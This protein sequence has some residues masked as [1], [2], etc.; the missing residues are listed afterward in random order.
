MRCTASALRPK[1]K[2]L[3]A[4]CRFFST[5]KA[6]NAFGKQNNW[7]GRRPLPTYVFGF[8]REKNETSKYKKKNWKRMHYMLIAR[9]ER[10]RHEY[11]SSGHCR[12]FSIPLA[13]FTS[14]TPRRSRWF[15]Q[16]ANQFDEITSTIQQ[17]NLA[18]FTERCQNSIRTYFPHQ[19]W[20]C[21]DNCRMQMTWIQSTPNKTNE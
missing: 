7:I 12:N 14:K 9:S 20:H 11:S 16:R 2:Y 4:R 1:W 3:A 17:H 19:H 21:R 15:A 5:T 18:L 8:F 10:T 6:C 13:C